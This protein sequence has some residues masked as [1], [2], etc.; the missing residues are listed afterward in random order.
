MTRLIYSR[1]WRS[2][3]RGLTAAILVIQGACIVAAARRL[4]WVT[5]PFVRY[6]VAFVAVQFA[7]LASL[8]LLLI[9]GK[10]VRLRW[11]WLRALRIRRLQQLVCD[12]G[13]R[14]AAVQAARR[15]PEEFLT[16]AEEAILA[17]KGSARDRVVSLLE[18][19]APYPRLL[20]QTSDRDPGRA[21][22]AI[23]L[24]GH[25]ENAQARA[26]VRRA[27]NHR[28]EAVQQAARKAILEG[29]DPESQRAVLEQ[30]AQLPAWPRLVMLH[31][32]PEDSALLP[33]F[34]AEALHSENEERII[35]ALELVL[36]RERLLLA[37]TP[38]RLAQAAS[39]EIRIKFFK[40]LPY[41]TVEGDLV[42][43]LQTGLRD[44]DWRVR[45]MAAR[46]CAHFRPAVLADRLLEICRSA[47][48]PAE[49]AHAARALAAMGGEGWLRLQDLAH[50]EIGS[51][52]YIATEAVERRLLGGAA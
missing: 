10:H 47:P 51:A 44:A 3:A 37:P 34:I 21:I 18:A 14:Q 50:S 27:L 20:R 23:S 29:N 19:S 13:A 15:W 17:L 4:E 30:A 7:V 48:N 41:L 6:A 52:R 5:D 28:I 12:A 45:A 40:A 35:V 26:A 39:P 36:T 33:A 31:Y 49:S 43:V 32:A 42:P 11:E 38:A 9:A 24:L 16:V 1:H 22:R 2:F 25:L 8:I 46:A